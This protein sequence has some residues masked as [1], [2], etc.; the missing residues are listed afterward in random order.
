MWNGC[1]FRHAKQKQPGTK[2]SRVGIPSVQDW[3]PVI[4]GKGAAG[5]PIKPDIKRPTLTQEQ[6]RAKK[7]ELE[8]EDFR[9]ETVS[10]SAASEIRDLRAKKGWTQKQLA[11]A[12]N[13][14]LHTVS[15]W[16]SGKAI[17]N[18]GLLV[19]MRR[20]LK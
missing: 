9:V 7:A 14:P 4:I 18:G 2:M 20:V 10:R 17:P 12:I 8:T 13:E 11:Q 16:E 3:H 15:A 1:A 6:A 19:K 5:T